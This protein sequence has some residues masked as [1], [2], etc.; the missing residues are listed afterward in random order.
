MTKQEATK[1]YRDMQNVVTRNAKKAVKNFHENGVAYWENEFNNR[2]CYA[3]AWRLMTLYEVKRDFDID[4]MMGWENAI[5]ERL[6]DEWLDDQEGV[7]Y[8]MAIALIEERAAELDD[9][10]GEDEL[11]DDMLNN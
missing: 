10:D 8:Q 1:I 9:E 7:N 3:I 11:F 5:I 6:Y 2:T 4:V